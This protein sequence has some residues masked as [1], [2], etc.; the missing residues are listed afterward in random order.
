MKWISSVKLNQ[1]LNKL[2]DNKRISVN[3]LRH[4]YLSNKYQNTIEKPV[5]N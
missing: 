1:H 2:F 4:S 5:M 3:A